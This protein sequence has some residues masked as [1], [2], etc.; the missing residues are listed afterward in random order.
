MADQPKD[1]V[2]DSDKILAIIFHL[3]DEYKNY[4]D[5]EQHFGQKSAHCDT[6]PLWKQLLK[7]EKIKH[8][9]FI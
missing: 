4:Y 1:E 5:I 8:V 6:T 3:M 9:S 2:K 7:S